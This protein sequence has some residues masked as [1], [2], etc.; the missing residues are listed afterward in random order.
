[1]KPLC[2]AALGGY[3]GGCSRAALMDAPWRREVALGG[4]GGGLGD[5]M[6]T[7]SLLTRLGASW[8]NLG[9]SLRNPTQPHR[10]GT[11]LLGAKGKEPLPPPTKPPPT[12]PREV[13]GFPEGGEGRRG[14]PSGLFL[15]VTVGEET[16]R[17]KSWDP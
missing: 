13:G 11:A 12:A 14:D 10:E 4:P 8:R 16:A 15:A 3:P 7:L 1:M 6:A 9:A 5:L 17:G 2:E